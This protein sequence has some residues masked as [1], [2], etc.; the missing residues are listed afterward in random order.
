M[1]MFRGFLAPLLEFRGS[2]LLL[3]KLFFLNDSSHTARN[4]IVIRGVI[5][6]LDIHCVLINIYNPCSV[7]GKAIIWNEI[8]E[9]WH[10]TN[11]PALIMGDFNEVLSPLEKGSNI[12]SQ[13]GVNEFRNFIQAVQVIELSVANRLFTCFH[14]NQKSKLDRCLMNSDWITK[15]PNLSTLILNRTISDHFPI[16]AHSP[17]SNWGRKPFRFMN[18]WVSHPNYMKIVQLAWANA[19]HLSIFDKLKLIK[20]SLKQWNKMSLGSL[21]TK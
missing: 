16:M 2:Y 17:S 20:G 6:S 21:M 15:F 4:Q 14:E 3:G 5:P 10:N 9:Y 19:Q 7:D 11:L 18:C 1:M 12:V 8:L 13:D